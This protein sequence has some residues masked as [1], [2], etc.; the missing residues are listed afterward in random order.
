MEVKNP[1]FVSGYYR[2]E[3]FCD[4]EQETQL[5]TDALHN[6][7][8]LTLMS[9]RRMGKTG[10][11]KHVFYK[12]KERQPDVVTFYMDIYA[13]QNLADFVRLFANTVLGSLDS[14]SKKAWN[15]ITK[16]LKNC[17][18][19]ITV[20][21]LT[22][23][24][25][26]TVEI[27]PEDEERSLKEIV[28]YLGASEKRC[29]I[30][31]DEFQQ[32]TNYPQKGVEALL[33]SYIQF[34]PNVNFIF[35]GSKQH[36]MQEMFLSA[37]KPFYQ[38]TQILTVGPIDK[39]VYYGFAARF[40][41]QTKR[42]LPQSIFEAVY[43]RFDGH[44]WYIQSILNRLYGAARTVNEKSVDE[45]VTEILE[46]A[47]YAYEHLLKAYSEASGRLLKAIA[48]EGCV[49][50]V[51]AGDFIA[52]HHLVAASSVRGVLQKLIDNELV[53][54]APEGYI[55]YDRFMGEWLRRQKF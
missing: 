12:L 48:I 52:R 38:S 13:T 40:F 46:E 5:I 18:P 17:R 53:Y 21:E 25:K 54:K 2:P 31:I 1:F 28:D 39:E 23:A 14:V 55:I 8:N 30:A 34:L 19:V 42:D 7:R 43:H 16:F 37:K 24:P 32:I 10:L 20:D 45:A 15:R 3:Y 6:G 44:T 51:L 36:V 50:A 11:I 26:I 47:T 33:R 29:Y 41:A 4:R 35:S 9:P 22:G 27:A 49:K